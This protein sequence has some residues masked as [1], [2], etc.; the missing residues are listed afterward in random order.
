MVVLRCHGLP[1][2]GGL[3][4]DVTVHSLAHSL[5]VL[6][7]ILAL[8]D[9]DVEIG[10]LCEAEIEVARAIGIRVQKVCAC[11]VEHGHEV[12]ADGV[13]AFCRE[14]AQALL[15]VLDELVSVRTGI[16]DALRNGKTLHDAPSHA[17][18][19][20]IFTQVAYLLPGPYLSVRHVVQGCDDTLYSYFPE[21]GKRNLV[22][23][24]KPSPCFFHF[25]VCM[26]CFSMS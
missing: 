6:L 1:E 7:R 8:Q 5:P 25:A 26:I 24:A 11:P 12:V 14:V 13:D 16:F 10:E 20:D 15:V 4:N 21:H 23:L 19:L 9:V 3:P 18:A 22:V 2:C 17:V